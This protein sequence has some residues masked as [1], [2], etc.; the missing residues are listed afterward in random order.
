MAEY[1]SV[2]VCAP[3]QVCDGAVR[4]PVFVPGR[5]SWRQHGA[6]PSPGQKHDGLPAV[7]LGDPL[8]HE[9]QHRQGHQEQPFHLRSSGLLPALVR[10][11]SVCT[12]VACQPWAT[13]FPYSLQL[14]IPHTFMMM[15]YQYKFQ[16]EDQ[17]KI[18]GSIK[19][20]ARIYFFLNPLETVDV[21]HSR[22]LEFVCACVAGLVSLGLCWNTARRGKSVDTA[23]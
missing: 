6:G 5:A 10:R 22:L 11:H 23:F 7:A 2:C 9:H 13:T 8:F 18:K 12:P 4:T 1:A 21:W 3:P 15:S 17:T 19:F 14:G 20:V 16:D